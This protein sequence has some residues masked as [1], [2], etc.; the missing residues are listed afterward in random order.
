MSCSLVQEPSIKEVGT[1]VLR[2]FIAGVRPL[3]YLVS[4]WPALIAVVA[5]MVIMISGIVARYVFNQ[6]L[7]WIDEYVGYLMALVTLLPLAWVL[8][9]ARHIRLTLIIQGLPGRGSNYLQLITDFIALAVTGVL[10][11]STIQMVRNSFA[12]GMRAWTV[13]E[14]PLGP[15]QLLMPIGFGL[16]AIAVIIDIIHRIR[17]VRAPSEEGGEDEK[18]H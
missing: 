4:K 9:H 11:I 17:G 18:S 15:V 6:P 10:L 5:M 7:H 12:T 3:I 14:T 13:R 2:K 16:F 8:L 1:N